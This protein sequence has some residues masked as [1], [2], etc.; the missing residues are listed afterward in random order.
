LHHYYQMDL[1]DFHRRR[2]GRSGLTGRK[3]DNLVKGLPPE[4]M[5]ITAL[6][7]SMPEG[8]GDGIAP[9]P[10][11][12]RWSNTEMLLAGLLDESRYANWAFMAANSKKK[13]KF[14]E[15]VP[16]PGIM[17]PEK[18]EEKPRYTLERAAMIDPRLRAEHEA[19]MREQGGG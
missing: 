3:L 1:L 5:T 17:Q 8:T 18:N 12:G 9:D 2:G 14:P 15:P 7:N 16:R 13:P 19:Q 11:K 4:S 10:G 6:R